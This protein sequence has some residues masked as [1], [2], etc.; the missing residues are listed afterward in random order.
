MLP[1]IKILDAANEIS[2]GEV[3]AK[4]SFHIAKKK[5]LVQTLAA[6]TNFQAKVKTF[7]KNFPS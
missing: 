6:F 2:M 1:T 7:L 3:R 4:L 5:A